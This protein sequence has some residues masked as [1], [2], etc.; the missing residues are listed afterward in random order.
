MTFSII[1]QLLPCATENAPGSYIM[2]DSGAGSVRGNPYSGEI[3]VFAVFGS[4]VGG[5]EGETP[6]AKFSIRF[7]IPPRGV[8]YD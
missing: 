5:G 6:R 1:R 2:D 8:P 7:S 3:R 4:R